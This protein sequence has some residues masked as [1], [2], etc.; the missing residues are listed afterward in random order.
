MDGRGLL[1]AWGEALGPVRRGVALAHGGRVAG[2]PRPFG[3]R[4]DLPTGPSAVSVVLTAAQTRRGSARAQAA[5][6]RAP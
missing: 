6:T 4:G 1:A 3:P 5:C 2:S